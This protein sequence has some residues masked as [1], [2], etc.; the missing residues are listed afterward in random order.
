MGLSPA[1]VLVELFGIEAAVGLALLATVL[2]VVVTAGL[3]ERRT[4][5]RPRADREERS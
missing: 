2:V 5:T 3:R 1:S 4:G